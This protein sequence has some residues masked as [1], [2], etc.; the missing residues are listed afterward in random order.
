LA[1]FTIVT[2]ARGK[3]FTESRY[4]LQHEDHRVE[5][6]RMKKKVVRTVLLVAV[7]GALAAIPASTQALRGTTSS[8]DDAGVD[9]QMV[10]LVNRLE[11]SRQQMETLHS[12]ILGL[13]EKSNVLGGKRSAFEQEMI[14]FSGTAEE[15]DVRLAAYRQEM[16]TARDA[17]HQDQIA[18]ID[19]VKD[20]LSM[21]QG[22]ILTAAYPGITGLLPW[23]LSTDSSD[24]L[25]QGNRARTI[26]GNGRL[27]MRDGRQG[28]AIALDAETSA[29][30]AQRAAGVG[31]RLQ[32]MVERLRE[33]VTDRF[34]QRAAGA[35]SAATVGP[36]MG[37]IEFQTGSAALEPGAPS[38]D[39]ADSAVTF[40]TA[41]LLPLGGDLPMA[42]PGRAQGLTNW[43][44]R[45]A[46]VLELK[47][48]A[49]T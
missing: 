10:L 42:S 46:H 6:S 11:L 8:S 31:E 21:K 39:G 32:A 4:V 33:R 45:L 3:A 29:D 1:I 7:F 28:L 16:K 2:S 38:A 5:G 24:A 9:L 12:A 30:E 14:A 35:S 13:V 23:S 15:L 20:T 43:L 41:E 25:L 26:V 19:T 49:M 27:M 22:E 40:G 47:L 18:A 36:M 17:L 37:T 48:A 44:E 34:A